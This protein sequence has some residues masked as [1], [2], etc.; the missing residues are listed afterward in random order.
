MPL[1]EWILDVKYIQQKYFPSLEL[2]AFVAFSQD[3]NER[4]VASHLFDPYRMFLIT[5]EC[6]DI[7]IQLILSE[8]KLFK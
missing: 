6:I 5:R 7:N 2:Y 3:A 1:G 8:V 4:K